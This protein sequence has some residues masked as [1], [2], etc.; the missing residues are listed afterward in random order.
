[1]KE[2]AEEFADS[3]NETTADKYGDVAS[4]LEAALDSLQNAL[5]AL[6]PVR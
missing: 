4:E 2:R 3:E 1:M 5:D 6:E